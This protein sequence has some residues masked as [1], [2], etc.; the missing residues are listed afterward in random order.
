MEMTF[1][2]RGVQVTDEIRAQ[3]EHKMAHLSRLEPR[4]TT[5]D[6]EFISEHHP[7]PDAVTRVDAAARIPRKTFRARAE[8]L[9]VPS[10]LDEVREKLERQLRDH[11]G[12]R[13]AAY[14][15]GV[16]SP[17]DGRGAVDGDADADR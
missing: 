1:T 17:P 16:G 3:A 13:R 12:K 9:D 4:L 5:L 11:H 8:A 7:K 10:A 2:G 14:K 6:L 15:G